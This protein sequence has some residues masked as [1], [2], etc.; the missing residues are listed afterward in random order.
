MTNKFQDSQHFFEKGSILYYEQKKYKKAMKCFKI[1]MKLNQ[2]GESIYNIGRM[3]ERGHGVTIDGEKAEKYYKLACQKGISKAMVNLS[4]LYLSGNIIEKNSD[5]AVLYLNEACELNDVYAIYNLGLIYMEGKSI[6]K[7]IEKS[8]ELMEKGVELNHTR[9]M[10]FLGCI[11]IEG[12]EIHQNIGKGI[13]YFLQS[14]MLNDREA[15]YNL[16]LLHLQYK[17]L[18]GFNF[19]ESKSI[20]QFEKGSQLKSPNCC[21]MLS[22]LYNNGQ[23]VPRDLSKSLFYYKLAEEYYFTEERYKL[24]DREEFYN[25][26]QI[27]LS[28]KYQEN[29]WKKNSFEDLIIYCEI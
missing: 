10:N 16:G 26:F 6:E 17:L 29:I 25:H 18:K 28:L 20:E 4:S 24:E 11:Y 23:I 12:K 13:Q 2:H 27:L 1:S 9:A 21:K 8:I 5:L 3:Y 14:S 7:N 19:H 15:I 22:K